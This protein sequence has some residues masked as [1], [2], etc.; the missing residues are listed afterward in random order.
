MG[1]AKNIIVRPIKPAIANKFVQQHHYSGKAGYQPAGGGLTPTSALH[2]FIAAPAHTIT[3]T[4]Q[5]V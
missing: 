1:R 3:N 2:F 4:T 5:G